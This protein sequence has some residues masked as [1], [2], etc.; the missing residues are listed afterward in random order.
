MGW[1]GGGGGRAISFE[2]LPRG[3]GRGVLERLSHPSRSDPHVKVRVTVFLDTLEEEVK[4][5]RRRPRFHAMASS[6]LEEEDDD[7]LRERASGV[8]A[9][10]RF[11]ADDMFVTDDCTVTREPLRR[12]CTSVR[13]VAVDLAAAISFLLKSSTSRTL[14]LSMISNAMRPNS[15]K[16]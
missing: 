11:V 3:R 7:R 14:V 1:G 10:D 16:A 2:D 13:A 6:K 12:L 5:P 15:T 8:R 4:D 9:D